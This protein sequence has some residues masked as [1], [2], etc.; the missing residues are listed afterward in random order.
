MVDPFFVAFRA[1][2][3]PVAWV[4]VGCPGALPAGTDTW[5]E[6]P[7]PN[8]V[9]LYADG[10]GSGAVYQSGPRPQ[11]FSWSG[12]FLGYDGVNLLLTNLG[13]SS[14]VTV[15][16][17]TAAP[18][19]CDLIVDFQIDWEANTSEAVLRDYLDELEAPAG[20]VWHWE[21]PSS[22]LSGET[23]HWCKNG[24][25]TWTDGHVR[26]LLYKLGSRSGPRPSGQR[27]IFNLPP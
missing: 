25:L 3:T 21:Y 10:N 6:G 12:I 18:G 15:Q 22:E 26:G 19:I 5:S 8:G 13:P 11:D 20:A 16:L 23:F 27:L 7:L 17:T 2:I 24:G 4:G 14:V 9:F 1:R